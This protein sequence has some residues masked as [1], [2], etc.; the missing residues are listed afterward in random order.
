M[1]FSFLLGN[2]VYDYVEKERERNVL[3]YFN[4][5]YHMMLLLFS[6]NTQRDNM[7]PIPLAMFLCT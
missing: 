7:L 4:H 2:Y 1:L 5:V 3:G 6:E